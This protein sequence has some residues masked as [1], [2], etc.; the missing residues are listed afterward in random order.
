MVE[1]FEKE[2]DYEEGELNNVSKDV[3]RGSR[4]VPEDTVILGEDNDA[5]YVDEF[6][7]HTVI[8]RCLV[9]VRFTKR[10]AH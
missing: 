1:N 7:P 8:Y 10:D 4:V 6:D 3:D 2:E 9:D 5:D